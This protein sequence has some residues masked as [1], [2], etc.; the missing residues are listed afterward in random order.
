MLQVRRVALA[1]VAHFLHELLARLLL[2]E[3]AY[4]GKA[5]ASLLANVLGFLNHQLLLRLIFL[6][7]LRAFFY[8]ALAVLQLLRT[9]VHR[10]FPAAHAFL[11]LFGLG[12]G[13]SDLFIGGCTAVGDAPLGFKF[14]SACFGRAL[15]AGLLYQL[16]A[17]AAHALQ[18]AHAQPP[19]DHKRGQ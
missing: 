6:Q 11:R 1:V 18:L 17:F 9:F 15:N 13:L 5:L 7:G 3:A 8:R 10:N 14:K 12:Q 4:F 16:L 19:H 2:R